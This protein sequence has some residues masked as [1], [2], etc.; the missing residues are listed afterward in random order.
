MG[1]SKDQILS[2]GAC[3][4]TV[5]LRTLEE[6]RANASPEESVKNDKPQFRIER[7]GYPP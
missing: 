6:H 3:V 5:T 2:V 1:P 4:A 7:F